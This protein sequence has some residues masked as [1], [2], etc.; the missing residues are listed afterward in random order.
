MEDAATMYYFALNK[1]CQAVGLETEGSSGSQ[2]VTGIFQGNL[3]WSRDS[4]KEGAFML[5]DFAGKVETVEM[6][7]KMQRQMMAVTN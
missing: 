5:R 6:G 7:R 1:W 2:T 3:L 4:A